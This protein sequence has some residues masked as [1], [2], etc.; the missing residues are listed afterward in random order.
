MCFLLGFVDV[1][2][3]GEM[4]DSVRNIIKFNLYLQFIGGNM[5]IEML[6][7]QVIIFDLVIVGVLG[8]FISMFEVGWLVVILVYGIIS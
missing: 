4:L 1:C 5:G 6:D 7:V 3:N 8:F 2:I